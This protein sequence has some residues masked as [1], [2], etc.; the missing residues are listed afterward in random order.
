MRTIWRQLSENPVDPDGDPP[1]AA[2]PATKPNYLRFSAHGGEPEQ[3]QKQKP[4]AKAVVEAAAEVF[5][6][7]NYF[8]G[9]PRSGSAICVFLQ[10]KGSPPPSHSLVPTDFTVSILSTL[11]L[12]ECALSLAPGSNSLHLHSQRVT[13][14]SVLRASITVVLFSTTMSSPHLSLVACMYPASLRATRLHYFTANCHLKTRWYRLESV[15]SRSMLMPTSFCL[16][17]TSLMMIIPRALH[18]PS[19]VLMASYGLFGY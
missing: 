6:R 17:G 8:V 16:K 15:S 2:K 18:D 9:L 7:E 3:K 4:E 13:F 11:H 1:L 12:A 14:V 5:R 19:L 10:K